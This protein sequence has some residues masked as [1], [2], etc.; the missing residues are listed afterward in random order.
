[1]FKEKQK[2][3]MKGEKLKCRAKDGGKNEKEEQESQMNTKALE[4]G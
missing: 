1:M 3:K 4:R 2:D